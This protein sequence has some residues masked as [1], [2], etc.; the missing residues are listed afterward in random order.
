MKTRLFFV[1][2]S[3][4][5]SFI[6]CV[7]NELE[8]GQDA[9]PKDFD[10]IECINGHTVHRDCIKDE[11]KTLSEEAEDMLSYYDLEEY[12][13][14]NEEDISPVDLAKYKEIIEIEHKTDYKDRISYDLG[15]GVGLSPCLEI[16]L[17]EA[18]CPMCNLGKLNNSLLLK[19]LVATENVI[20]EDVMKEIRTRFNNYKEF[21]EWVEKNDK[22][23]RLRLEQLIE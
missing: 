12:V 17:S 16:G 8:A 3:S 20:I 21:E 2:N 19:Y 7:C 23:N 14:S 1:S 22:K 18:L 15:N 13:E 11:L 9:S 10:M 5:S 6:C 4:T